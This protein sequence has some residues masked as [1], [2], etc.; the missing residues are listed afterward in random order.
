[1]EYSRHYEL[2]DGVLHSDVVG[3]HSADY[4]THF[5]DT[6]KLALIVELKEENLVVYRKSYIRVKVLPLGIHVEK[7]CEAFDLIEVQ[8]LVDPA[9]FKNKKVILSVNKIDK[10][11]GIIE[12]LVAYT[13]LIKDPFWYG[14]VVFILILSPMK[15]ILRDHYE[16]LSRYIYNLVCAINQKYRSEDFLPIEC[17]IWE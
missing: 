11:E 6:C 9:G 12:K 3:F 10:S 15:T 14:E 17:K 16:D 4:V 13:N 7:F 8:S 1:M 2:M 5:L